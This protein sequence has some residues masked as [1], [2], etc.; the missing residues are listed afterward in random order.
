VEVAS[1]KTP[2]HSWL[3]SWGK[4]FRNVFSLFTRNLLPASAAGERPEFGCGGIIPTEEWG[5]E[6]DEGIVMRISI[7]ER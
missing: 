4:R 3:K 6:N 1:N 7:S 2:R 5:Q